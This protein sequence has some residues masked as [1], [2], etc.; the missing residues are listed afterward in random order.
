MKET[1]R[2]MSTL[3]LMTVAMVIFACTFTACSDDEMNDN[4]DETLF[5][6][7]LTKNL[8][9]YMEADEQLHAARWQ[10]DRGSHPRNVRE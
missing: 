7:P 1:I 9:W 6:R 2:T 5:L 3:L 4:T 10:V 8:F